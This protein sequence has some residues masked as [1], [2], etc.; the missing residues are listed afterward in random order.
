MPWA[1]FPPAKRGLYSTRILGS[2]RNLQ[3]IIGYFKK[4]IQKYLDF[5][6]K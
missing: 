1:L 3:Q 4:N 6:H 5:S 2:E